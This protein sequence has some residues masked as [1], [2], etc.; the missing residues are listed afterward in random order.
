MCHNKAL[1]FML[2][3]YLGGIY[4]GKPFKDLE[5]MS[6]VMRRKNV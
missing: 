2:W 1:P 4:Q 6:T 3:Q 5:K